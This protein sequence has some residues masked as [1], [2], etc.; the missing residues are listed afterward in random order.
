MTKL[1]NGADGRQGIGLSSLAVISIV[2]FL[3]GYMFS[4]T[5]TGERITNACVGDVPGLTV[6]DATTSASC[7]T[8]LA[9]SFD[10]RALAD[11]IAGLAQTTL[12]TTPE[13]LELTNAVLQ[14]VTS[15][16]YERQVHNE[17]LS[18]AVR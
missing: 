5:I 9:E 10:S 7:S 15:N 16:P 17:N 18:Y 8:V 12:F 3:A 14:A 4:G 6:G 13:K 2:G 11:N 1:A